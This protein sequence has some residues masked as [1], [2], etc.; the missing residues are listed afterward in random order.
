MY[1]FDIK[2]LLKMEKNSNEYSD[3]VILKNLGHW[4]GML[5]LARNKP[6]LYKV[7]FWSLNRVGKRRFSLDK[8][9]IYYLYKEMDIKSLLIEAYFKGEQV[10]KNNYEA[11]NKWRINLHVDKYGYF[12]IYRRCYMLF[13]LLQKYL[14]V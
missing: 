7:S 10:I 8:F 13:L 3:R 4:L 6:V 5:T 11:D 9:K 12:F 14:T 2:V 1:T